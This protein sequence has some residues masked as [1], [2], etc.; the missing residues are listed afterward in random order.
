MACLSVIF[1]GAHFGTIL[2]YSFV[3]NAFSCCNFP[4]NNYISL[5]FDQL[6]TCFLFSPHVLFY[7]VWMGKTRVFFAKHWGK[8]IHLSVTEILW[9]FHVIWRHAFNISKIYH[10]CVSWDGLLWRVFH[11][12][13]NRVVAVF[14]TTVHANGIFPVSDLW[15]FSFEKRVQLW[16]TAHLPNRIL[17]SF[18]SFHARYLHLKLININLKAVFFH[19]T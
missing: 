10:Y 17:G 8:R 2:C 12:N 6:H 11:R 1:P 7:S 5:S 18:I 15:I 13:V 4:S 16:N 19:I 3:I 9:W 14:T